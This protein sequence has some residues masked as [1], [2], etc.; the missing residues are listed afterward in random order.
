MDS[1]A[2][3]W[4]LAVI[5]L[6]VII[7]ARFGNNRIKAELKEDY[8]LALKSGD[9]KRALEAGRKYYSKLRGGKLKL[10]DEQA[11]ANDMKTME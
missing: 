4:T 7:F 9:K 11:I 3:L 2:I 1:S 5:I 6:I 10:Q 8:D